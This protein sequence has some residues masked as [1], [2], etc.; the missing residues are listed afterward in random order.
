M[1]PALQ[2][3]EKNAKNALLNK[4][5]TEVRYLTDEEMKTLGWYKRPICFTLN[6]GTTCIISQDNEGN[7]GGA[8]LYG[9][10]GTIPTMK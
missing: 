1:T 5:I 3:Q 9:L 6:D 2:Q 10:D 4:I 7:N 8:I